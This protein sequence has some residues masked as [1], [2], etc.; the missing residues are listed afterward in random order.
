MSS[1]LDPLFAVLSEVNAQLARGIPAPLRVVLWSM[2]GAIVSMEL[3]RL[4]TSQARLRALKT[5]L[6]S[7]QQRVADFDGDFAEGWP[8]V[9]RML[10][11]ALKRVALVLPATLMASLP[12]LVLI[13]WLAVAYGSTYPLPGSAVA[14]EVPGTLN[15]RWIDADAVHPTPRVEITSA[16]GDVLTSAEV[17]APVS[18]LA[19]RRWWNTILGNPAGYLPDDA[20]VDHLTIDLPRQAFLPFSWEWLRGWEAIFLPAMVIGALLYKRLRRIE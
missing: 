11:L 10:G 14:V 1:L 19:K 18:T 13:L 17:G 6:R 2:V 4:G 16:A 12:L 7:M 15:G 20:P 3:Y 8:L 5:S 9:R